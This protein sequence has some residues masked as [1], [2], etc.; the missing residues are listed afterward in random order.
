MLGSCSTSASG[1]SVSSPSLVNFATSSAS[2]EIA[3]IIM[4]VNESK[5]CCPS[6]LPRYTPSRVGIVRAAP[7]PGPR[8]GIAWRAA[9]GGELRVTSAKLPLLR[10]LRP[11]RR[12]L[13]LRTSAETLRGKL[14][15]VEDGRQ[16]RR[17]TSKP[18]GSA[19]QLL[20]AQRPA[21]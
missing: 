19:R 1:W 16:A 2:P 13:Q 14:R 11:R 18:S 17:P 7:S 5:S 21:A 4:L 9:A 10:V 3:A 12:C 20:P 15:G 6:P 8:R